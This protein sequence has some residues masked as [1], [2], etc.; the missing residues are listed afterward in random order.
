MTLELEELLQY[1]AWHREKWRDW[2]QQQGNAPLAI[3]IGAN[4]D[5]R[6]QSIGD[7]IRHV[8]SAEK[9]YV[10]RLLGRPIT[11]TSFL[12][13]GDVEALFAFGGERRIV[14]HILLHEIR[15]WAQIA[16]LLRLNG[17]AVEWHDFLFFAAE[18]PDDPRPG[19]ASRLS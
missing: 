15:H 7:V 6:F 10:D 14:V 13:T 11:D 18:E 12:P 16:T 5:G 9:R 4:G 3:S 19:G 2:F 8:F 17:F 1:S